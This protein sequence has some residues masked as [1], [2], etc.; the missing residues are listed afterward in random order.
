MLLWRQGRIEG[1]VRNN[2]AAVRAHS[3]RVWAAQRST[4]L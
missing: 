3:E 4:R 2:L 1:E